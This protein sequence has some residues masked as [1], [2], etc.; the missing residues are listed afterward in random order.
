MHRS[1]DHEDLVR[2]GFR[3]FATPVGV[4]EAKRVEGT[5]TMY[6]GRA[7]SLRKRIDLL[8][9]YGGGEP[10]AHQGGRYLWQ[11]AEPDR[12]R[13]A[14]KLDCD[15]VAAEADLLDEFEAAFARLPFANIVRGSRTMVPA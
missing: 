9:R 8:A 12:L 6:I 11:I 5:P 13:I 14:W 7:T 1:F 4:L 10:V 3:G 15:P 2:R